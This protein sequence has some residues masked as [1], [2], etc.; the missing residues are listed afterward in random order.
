[1]DPKT[2]EYIHLKKFL[3]T[4]D[5]KHVEWKP[6]TRRKNVLR[7]LST[8]LLMDKISGDLRRCLARYHRKTTWTL[9]NFST[10]LARC[11]QVMEKMEKVRSMTK[12]L[13]HSTADF[14]TEQTQNTKTHYRFE[15]ETKDLPG[16]KELGAEFPS[17]D[18]HITPATA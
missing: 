13:T 10:A 12:I 15:Y 3:T 5:Y 14:Y 4:W 1:M 16:Q 17:V 6:K 8:L 18:H 9:D 2:D 11:L 7:D